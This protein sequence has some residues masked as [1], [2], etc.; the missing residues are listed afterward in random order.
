MPRGGAHFSL[1]ELSRV[2]NQYN[3]GK[4][5]ETHTLT[6][7][8]RRAPKKIIISEFGKYLLKRRARGKDD[9]YHVAFTHE[10]QTFLKKKSYAVSG[11]VKTL[12]NTTALS[13]NSHTYELFEFMPGDRFD[14]SIEGAA[15]AGRE[16]A[17]LHEHFSNFVFRWEVL[18]RTYHDSSSVRGHL[19]TIVSEKSPHEPGM[20]WRI[21]A[22]KL[23]SYYDRA[24]ESVNDKGF[25]EWPDQ[26]VH[27]DWHPGN[28]LF[29]DRKVSCVLDFDSAKIAPV[30]TDLAN[31]ALQFSIL[32]GKPDP[33]DW[34][35]CLDRER[36][37]GFVL[38]Y[39]EI[40]KLPGEMLES[41]PDLMIE[42]MIAEAVLPIATTGF[43]GHLSGIDFLKMI[44][45][46]C[47]WIDDN[48]KFLKD[49]IFGKG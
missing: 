1:E 6:T 29:L 18:K 36:F 24:S 22:S 17:K 32:G 26:I 35:C 9:L 49:D 43:F 8:N 21:T 39:H 12:D 16:L 33:E 31:G 28:M 48:R 34:P 38:G 14:G 20:G 25:C 37:R 10:I 46:K 45:R 15:E 4:V 19:D 7:G 30:V 2:L 23:V 11:V 47:R 41:L 13:L 42:I 27:G 5:K 3:I 40:Q 44:L